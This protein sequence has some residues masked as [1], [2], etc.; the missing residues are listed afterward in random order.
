VRPLRVLGIGSPFGDDQVGWRVAEALLRFPICAEG[1]L[2]RV[3][4]AL[5]DRPGARLLA[6]AEGAELLVLV[7]AVQSGARPGTVHRLDDDAA[8][9]ADS[10]LSGHGFGVASALALGRALGVLSGRVALYGVEIGVD[11]LLLDAPLTP[12]VEQAVPRAA[13][14]IAHE[15]CTYLGA[16]APDKRLCGAWLQ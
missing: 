15:L 16:P 5:C 1:V 14:R 2:A 6:L 11:S 13:E 3:S 4:V 7:D 12:M 10:L 9:I 8:A